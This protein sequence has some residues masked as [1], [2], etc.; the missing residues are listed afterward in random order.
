MT[1]DRGSGA[2]QRLIG[3]GDLE[4]VTASLEQ[5]EVLLEDARR[6]L[7]SAALIC[8]PDPLGA[9]VLTY[10]AARKALVGILEAQGL[11]ATAKG[12][13]VV[14]FDA[15]IAQFDPPLGKLIR[16]FNRMRARRNQVE[17]ASSS[18]PEVTTEE[19]LADI[20]KA[21]DLI[22]LAEQVLPRMDEF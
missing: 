1:W 16:P 15:A 13:H 9:Y 22:K 8:E 7:A 18:N 3:G 19:V 17:Y 4:R 20:E 21:R 10:D 12:G 14:L 6:H 2:I 5:A 11:R